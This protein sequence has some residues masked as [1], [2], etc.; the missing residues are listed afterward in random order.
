MFVSAE[1]LKDLKY[2]LRELYEDLVDI[3]DSAISQAEYD[4]VPDE[5]EVEV[6]DDKP[7]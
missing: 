5:Y 3:L 7:S 2:D 1:Q 6:R 4:D